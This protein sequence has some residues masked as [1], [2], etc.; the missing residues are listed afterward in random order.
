MSSDAK[1]PV[2]VELRVA[3]FLSVDTE[4]GRSILRGIAHYYRLRPEVTVLKF[5]QTGSYDPVQLRRLRL[6]GI[7]AKVGSRRDEAALQELRLPVVNVSGQIKTARVPTVDSDDARVG[8]L[9]FHHLQSRG[10]RNFAFC[11]N[12]RHHASRLRRDAFCRGAQQHD[13]K[14]QVHCFALS[15]GDQNS[16]FPEPVR[17]A[18]SAWLLGLPKPVGIFTFTDR[19]AVELEEM[20]AR[21][22]LKVPERIAILGVGNDLTRLEFSHVE[23]SSVQ[24]NTERIGILA[25]E[26][27]DQMMQGRGHPP[28]LLLVPPQKIVTR[29]STDRY[30]VHDEAVGEVLESIRYQIGKPIYVN[31]LARAAGLSRRALE[32]RFRKALG[33]SVYEA[34]ERMKLE[35]ARDL[36]SD[37]ALPVGEVAFATGYPD[38]KAFCRAFTRWSGESPSKFRRR[39]A[40]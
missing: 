13:G 10:H 38:G 36:L 7:I 25:A 16:P 28:R 32:L 11:G 6:G 39:T 22:E 21:M 24:L 14:L 5:G 30:T 26:S 12:P 29:R 37:A 17:S 1:A 2:P 20:C 4:H 3:T 23:L 40:V 15:Q 33:E 27:L 9:A 34:V 31:E 19:V 8:E 18:L 35:H